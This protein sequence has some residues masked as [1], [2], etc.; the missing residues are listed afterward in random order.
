M[1]SLGG[2]L[3]ETSSGERTPVGGKTLA[4]ERTAVELESLAAVVVEI[5][6]RDWLVAGNFV[7]QSV[8]G[9]AAVGVR[10]VAVVVG[11][12]V[13]VQMWVVAGPEQPAAADSKLVVVGE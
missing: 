1:E 2:F 4:G 9:L 8:K 7:A 6:V 13:A 12:F 5:L 10:I 11:S 3:G